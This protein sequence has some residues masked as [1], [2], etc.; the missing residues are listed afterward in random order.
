ML[1]AP[2]QT[3]E[4]TLHAALVSGTTAAMTWALST[5]ASI[6]IFSLAGSLHIG[7]SNQTFAI[8]FSRDEVK[9]KMLAAYI[10]RRKVA[11]LLRAKNGPLSIILEYFLRFHYELTGISSFFV[12]V[13]ARK[14]ILRSGLSTV[15]A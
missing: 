4:L 8:I 7:Q 3:L 2:D 15:A 1:T 10:Y 13:W 6:T 11:I 9:L 14:T 5:E 12:R